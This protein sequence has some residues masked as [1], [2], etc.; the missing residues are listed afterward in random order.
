MRWVKIGGSTYNLD[1]LIRYEQH[2]GER[3]VGSRGGIMNPE[4]IFREFRF[5]ALHF[6]DHTSVELD[7]PQTEAFL[8]CIGAD[9]GVLDLDKVDEDVVGHVFVKGSEAGDIIMSEE[10]EAERDRWSGPEGSMP[11]VEG[12]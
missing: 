11:K 6:L 2:I 10:D 5:V 7:G 12:A 8:R 4:P 9:G 1:T 3:E